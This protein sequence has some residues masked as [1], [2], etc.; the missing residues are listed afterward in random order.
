[1]GTKIFRH[2]NL[3]AAHVVSEPD[4]VS[5]MV[6]ENTALAIDAASVPALIRLLKAGERYS[7]RGERTI[8]TTLKERKPRAKK[9]AKDAAQ[10][11]PA[12]DAKPAHAPATA[13][14]VK[15]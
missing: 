10:A 6:G 11:T 1:M 7:T 13:A 9:D 15:K 8:E 3:T 2:E 4:K 12:S 5:I 14:N